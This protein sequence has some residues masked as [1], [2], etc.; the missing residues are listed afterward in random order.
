MNLVSYSFHYVGNE[1]TVV[2]LNWHGVFIHTM[3]RSLNC[4]YGFHYASIVTN[5]EEH[6]SFFKRKVRE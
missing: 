3:N 4:A 5:F 6:I 2:D 1:W